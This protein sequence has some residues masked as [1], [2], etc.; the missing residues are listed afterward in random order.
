[1]GNG[2]RADDG[3][4]AVPPKQSDLWAEFFPDLRGA[5]AARTA[6]LAVVDKGAPES[7]KAL[8]F[9]SVCRV[10]SHLATFIVDDVWAD[11]YRDGIGPPVVEKRAMGAVMQRARKEGVITPTDQFRPSAQKQ[12]HANPR[13]IWRSLHPRGGHE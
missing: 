3:V 7:F 13:R 10:A 1:M 6:A 12:C 9:V 8:A 4:T 11:L 2:K 5:Q